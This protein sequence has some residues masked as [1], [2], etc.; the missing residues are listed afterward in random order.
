MQHEFDYCVESYKEINIATQSSIDLMK[1][2][3]DKV[4]VFD[5]LSQHFD[6]KQ[7]YFTYFNDFG[8]LWKKFGEQI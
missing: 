6:F 1:S 3:S 4:L 5:P 2:D 8:R 7:I